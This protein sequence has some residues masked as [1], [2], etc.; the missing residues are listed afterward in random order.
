MNEYH[1][2]SNLRQH[3]VKNLFVPPLLVWLLYALISLI[4]L[5]F[6][7]LNVFWQ[8]LLG[9]PFTFSEV[10]TLSDR[11]LEFQ[12]RLGTPIVMLFWL[13]IGAATYTIIWLIENVLFIAKIEVEESKYVYRSPIM[14][15]QYWEATIKS[16][17]FLFFIVLLWVTLIAL[18]LRVLLPAFSHLFQS[19]LYSAPI[20][21]RL[22]NI[23]VAMIGNILAIYLL[24]LMRRIIT[25]SW[26][27]NRP[28]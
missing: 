16:N 6:L 11:F 10:S 17:L 7:N 18:Y 24:M 27:T 20:Y 25:H 8:N 22:L 26:N 9:R 13:F 2:G 12:D 1:S 3:R 23:V 15:H 14:R 28:V 4:V 19:G 21:Q 5:A